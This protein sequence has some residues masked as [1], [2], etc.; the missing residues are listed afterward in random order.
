M[1]RFVYFD[2]CYNV[3]FCYV[4]D[5]DVGKVIKVMFYWGFCGGLIII[6]GN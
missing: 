1:W 2:V 5:V 4:V 3:C 6:V